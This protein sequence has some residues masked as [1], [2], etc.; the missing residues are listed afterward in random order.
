MYGWNRSVPG[1]TRMKQIKRRIDSTDTNTCSRSG[2]TELETSLTSNL[3]PNRTE[4][5]PW[6]NFE[7]VHECLDQTHNNTRGVQLLIKREE[8]DSYSHVTPLASRSKLFFDWIHVIIDEK[9][10]LIQSSRD[11]IS[12]LDQKLDPRVYKQDEDKTTDFIRER[13]VQILGENPFWSK[14]WFNSCYFESNRRNIWR[15]CRHLENLL[16]YIWYP[17]IQH[18]SK[19]RCHQC[20][21]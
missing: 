15:C 8:L 11:Y 19:L 20:R 14:L 6:Q 13:T 9:S 7:A 10:F 3:E 5:E 12:L 4:P 1:A 2:R 17:M 21:R 16:G 18:P